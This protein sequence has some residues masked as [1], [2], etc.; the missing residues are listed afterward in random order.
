MELT[1]FQN[2]MFDQ[3]AIWQSPTLAASQ[4]PLAINLSKRDADGEIR[5]SL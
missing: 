5:V 2:H 3:F 1:I 4:I